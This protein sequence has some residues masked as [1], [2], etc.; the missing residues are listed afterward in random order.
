MCIPLLQRRV[1]TSVENL[2][3]VVEFSDRFFF[4]LLPRPGKVMEKKL[5]NINILGKVMESLMIQFKSS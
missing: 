1:H 3:K 2:G 4:F 5:I